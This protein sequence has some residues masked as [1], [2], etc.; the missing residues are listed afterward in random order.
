MN[1][2]NDD[3]WHNYS[4]VGIEDYGHTT[5][6]EY[7]FA[8]SYPAT[9]APLANGRA[10]KFTTDPPDTFYGIKEFNN[11]IAANSWLEVNPNPF[12]QIAKIRY[13]IHDTGYTIND[14][15]LAIYDVMGRLVKSFNLESSIQNQESAVRWDGTGNTGK[16]VPKGVYFVR[17]QGPYLN[18]TEKVILVE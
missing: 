17:L 11:N 6:L 1:I 2:T 5:G 10:I 4:T 3:V 8:N 18:I 15:T 9:A 13:R 12:A 16:R 14:P 7:T